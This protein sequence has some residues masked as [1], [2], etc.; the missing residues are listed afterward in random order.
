VSEDAPAV[1]TPWVLDIS[2]LVEVARGDIGT[3]T[4]VQEVDARGQ[5]LVI[6]ALAVTGASLDM[7]SGEAAELLEGL[8]QLKNAMTAALR[9]AEQAVRL[10]AVIARTGLD[11]WDA[12]VAAVADAAVC[13]ILT[14]DGARWRE[15]ATDLDE[16]LHFI[17]IAEPDE[18]PG[19]PGPGGLGARAGTRFASP[20]LPAALLLLRAGVIPTSAARSVGEVG[21]AEAAP[22]GRISPGSRPDRSRWRAYS[23]ACPVPHLRAGYAAGQPGMPAGQRLASAVMAERRIMRGPRWRAWSAGRPARAARRCKVRRTSAGNSR[24]PDRVAN[25]AWPGAW[26][27]RPAR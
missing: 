1:P 22:A 12:H 19:G 8:E 9:D 21:I 25:S 27:A 2:V 4:F 5:P 10:A 24:R 7:R 17:E 20:W 16:P 6:P 26:P 14:L 15:H 11:P 13:P 18:P 23:A 3:M